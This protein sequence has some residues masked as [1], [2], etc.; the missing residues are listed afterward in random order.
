MILA[1]MRERGEPFDRAFASAVQRMRAQPAMS[2]EDV[3]ELV[4]WKTWLRWSRP[5]WRWAYER[6]EGQ[7]PPLDTSPPPLFLDN[8]LQIA[9]TSKGGIADGR[10]RTA[11]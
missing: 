3:A 10:N 11:R 2:A 5:Y 8:S 1:G 9:A 4:D 6:G 7:P